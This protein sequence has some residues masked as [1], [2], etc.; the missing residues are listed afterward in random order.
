MNSFN[1]TVLT[2]QQKKP[3]QNTNSLDYTFFFIEERLI[4]R[5]RLKREWIFLFIYLFIYVLNLK[6]S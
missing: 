3:R 2:K 1:R 4:L 6:R 5:L